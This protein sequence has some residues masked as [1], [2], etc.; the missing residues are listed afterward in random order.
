V[1]PKFIFSNHDD[2]LQVLSEYLDLDVLPPIMNPHGHGTQ[3]P[4]FFEKIHMEGGLIPTE[5]EEED[6]PTKPEPPPTVAPEM[7]TTS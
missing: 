6:D 2:Y 3:M 5:E 1:H 7:A 4:G